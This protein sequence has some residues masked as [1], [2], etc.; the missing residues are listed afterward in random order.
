M[1]VY[2]K[3]TFYIYINVCY[4]P[5]IKIVFTEEYSYRYKLK[6][7]KLRFKCQYLMARLRRGRARDVLDPTVKKEAGQPDLLGLCSQV[8]LEVIEL[9]NFIRV[10][11]VSCVLCWIY[12][13]LS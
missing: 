6:S 1:A 8:P 9:G 12:L 4:F 2:V 11:I 3:V 7:T 10:L 13:Q 5:C